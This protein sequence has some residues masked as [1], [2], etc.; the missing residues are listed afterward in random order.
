MITAGEVMIRRT[1]RGRRPRGMGG[2]RECRTARGAVNTLMVYIFL[3]KKTRCSLD[4]SCA[5]SEKRNPRRWSR[6]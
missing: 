5:A 4:P 6:R 2:F 1:N 3:K